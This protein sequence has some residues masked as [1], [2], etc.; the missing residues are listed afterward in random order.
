MIWVSY[1]R[2][3]ESLHPV[4]ELLVRF[5]LLLWDI[6]VEDLPQL[7][8]DGPFHDFNLLVGMFDAT[9]SDLACQNLILC[10][11]QFELQLL[12]GVG[13]RIQGHFLFYLSGFTYDRVSEDALT[14]D[15]IEVVVIKHF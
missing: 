4:K 8:Q 5:P 7:A 9:I 3:S 11:F 14:E 15:G 2:V 1:N 13:I 12:L 6:L 10:C